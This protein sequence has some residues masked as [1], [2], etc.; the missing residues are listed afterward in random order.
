MGRQTRTGGA[1]RR[2]ML[3]VAA[4]VPARRSLTPTALAEPR[5]VCWVRPKNNWGRLDL[6]GFLGLSK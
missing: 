4:A 1:S 3:G 2:E 6:P 5:H